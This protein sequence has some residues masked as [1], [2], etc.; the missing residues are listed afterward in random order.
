MEF[1][2]SFAFLRV[3]ELLPSGFVVGVGRHPQLLLDDILLSEAYFLIHQAVFQMMTVHYKYVKFSIPGYMECFLK[4]ERVTG[5]GK[6][7]GDS[8]SRFPVEVCLNLAID[9]FDS[10]IKKV[11]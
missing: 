6:E 3:L 8:V 10:C 5:A 4:H 1:Y 9:Y 7:V 11:G 2:H